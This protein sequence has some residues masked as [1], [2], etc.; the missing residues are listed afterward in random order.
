M[1][2]ALCNGPRKISKSDV[3]AA[4]YSMFLVGVVLA[5]ADDEFF[6]CPA[7]L[8]RFA[9]K[10]ASNAVSREEKWKNKRR[11]KAEK[12]EEEEEAPLLLCRRVGAGDTAGCRDE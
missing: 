6:S 1:S 5:I 7:C 8:L 11:A 12:E 3:T 2:C 9:R 10:P 4:D